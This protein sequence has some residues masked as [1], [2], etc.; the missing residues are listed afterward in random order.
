MILEN[1]W[2][3]DAL[4][5]IR[6]TILTDVDTL[7]KSNAGYLGDDLKSQYDQAVAASSRPK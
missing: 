5:A 6:A 4:G 3:A 2:S 1:A 7:K